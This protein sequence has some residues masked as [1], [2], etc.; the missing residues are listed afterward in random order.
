M[1]INE[2]RSIAT[3]VKT[4]E[5]GSLREAAATQDNVAVTPASALTSAQAQAMTPSSFSLASSS[6]EWPSHVP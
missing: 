3:F 2:H 4:A 6:A 1:R 5:L